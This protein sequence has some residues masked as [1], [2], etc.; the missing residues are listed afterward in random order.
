MKSVD[1]ERNHDEGDSSLQFHSLQLY[2]TSVKTDYPTNEPVITEI[3]MGTAGLEKFEVDT[4]AS[5]SI[6]THEAYDRLKNM[7]CGNIP[8]LRP[9]T[10]TIQLADGSSSNKDMGSVSIRCQ[11]GNSDSK[12]LDFYVMKAPGNLLGRYAI[13]ML[14]PEVF[15]GLRAV[16]S[17]PT[18]K[19]IRNV[20]EV[21]DVVSKI[22]AATTAVQEESVAP[23]PLKR[24]IFQYQGVPEK[25]QEERV[26]PAPVKRTT[27][28][29]KCAPVT[30]PVE[31]KNP[32]VMN[33]KSSNTVSV[34]L[35][36]SPVQALSSGSGVGG[37]SVPARETS[38]DTT[39]NT[40][41]IVAALSEK[42][43]PELP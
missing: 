13:E 15:K 40:T 28:Q 31:K 20:T 32:V 37:S 1:V 6:L 21:P 16:A 29:Y 36:A 8:D 39:G 19:K 17:T 9:E 38:V 18:V 43:Q 7:P 12:K 35:C 24:T 27:S 14:W 5:H 41:T 10:R 23:I 34:C 26:V 2:A 3:K 30:V 22:D 42:L 33:K 25:V 11:A 4:A